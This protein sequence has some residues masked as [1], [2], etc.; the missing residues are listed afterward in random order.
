M[1]CGIRRE[2]RCARSR[3]SQA[4][5]GE[6]RETA[7]RPPTSEIRTGQ[8]QPLLGP[9]EGCFHFQ[10]WQDLAL[11]RCRTCKLFFLHSLS[12]LVNI[13][14]QSNNPIG[15]LGLTTG[16]LDSAALGNCFI[17]IYKY[18]VPADA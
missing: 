15:G 12:A 3:Y 7:P 2:N 14:L 13:Q 1:A 11:W 5:P 18:K 17:R 8:C 4:A 10:S 6:I 9:S 16:L